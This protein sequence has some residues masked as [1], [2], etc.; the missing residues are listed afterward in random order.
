MVMVL[1]GPPEVAPPP[2]AGA[3][4]AVGPGRGALELPTACRLTLEPLPLLFC[5]RNGSTSLKF[6]SCRRFCPMGLASRLVWRT[7]TFSALTG[8]FAAAGAGDEPAEDDRKRA[9][10]VSTAAAVMAARL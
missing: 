2:G 7:W 6:L 5:L 4:L 3:E 10:T 1:P 9:P 8:A